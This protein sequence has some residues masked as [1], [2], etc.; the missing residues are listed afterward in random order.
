MTQRSTEAIDVR[1]S[2]GFDILQTLCYKDVLKTVDATDS[3]VMF[4]G[5][6]YIERKFRKWKELRSTRSKM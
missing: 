1:G 4:V 5:K 3:L 6:I 2:S